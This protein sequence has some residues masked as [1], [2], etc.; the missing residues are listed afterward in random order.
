[1]LFQQKDFLKFRPTFCFLIGI[2]LLAPCT[3]RACAA[4]F[5]IV[6]GDVTGLKDAMTTA[7]G[8]SQDDTIELAAGGTYT[9]TARD[10]GLNGLPAVA[11]DGGHKLTIH[12]N[13]ATVQRSSAGGTPTFRIFY[14]NTGG[15]LTLSGLTLTNG[16]PGTFHG[17]AIY[18]DAETGN[19][20]L[21]ITNCTITGCSGDYGGAIFND[22]YQDPS[23]PPHTA[24]LTVTNS[25]FSNN[26]GTQY[27]GAIWNESGGIVMNVANS[28]FDGNAAI[29]RS[30][31]AIQF[32]GF[33]GNATG[34]ILNSTFTNNSCSNYGGAVN[35]DG[36]SGNAQLTIANCTFDGNLAG[37]GGGIAMDGSGGNATVT[38]ASCTFS[39]NYSTTLGDALY[40]SQ[41]GSG[42]TSAQIGNSIVASGD[43]DY[44]FSIDN[45]SGGTAAITSQGYNLSDDAAGGDGL[46]GPGGYLNHAGD[47]RNTDPLLD[48]A[49]L[50]A[51]GGPTAT[52]A[53]QATSPAL[54]RG[55]SNTILTNNNDQR[56][57]PRPF[58]DPNVTNASGGDG[59]DI[60]AYEAD[61]RTIIWAKV[62]SDFQLKFTTIVGHT[63]EVQ[64]R[65]ILNS[66]TW[67]TVND[68]VPAPP[69]S[70]TGGIVQVT[71]PNAF[72]F[73]SGFYRLHQLP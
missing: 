54:D 55:K 18:N 21:T 43:P 42:T 56:G 20:T 69:I 40:L 60:G 67:M 39:G 9:L 25:T 66:G 36:S 35:V 65:M 41:T 58:D 37:W 52:I 50:K 38:I 46:T 15:N 6:N 34:S 14:V 27:G 17:G 53:L 11:P 1:V 63:Y 23:F 32:D 16:N 73:S 64:N 49:G 71:V 3:Q 61:V 59:S 48:P 70:G 8:N 26:T 13:G 30:A 4:T 57:E 7:N 33:G 10:N 28:T 29:S 45:T 62:G 5:N 51:N 19:A 2:A 68:T 44:N 12:G 24:T 22:G 72:S 47:I 31:G